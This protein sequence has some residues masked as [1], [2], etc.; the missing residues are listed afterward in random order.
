VSERCR[1]T[2]ISWASSCSRS[3]SIAQRLGGRSY[4][5]YSPVWG[6]RYATII[7]KYTFQALKTLW[8]LFRTRPEVVLVMAPPVV[9]CTPVWIY[10]K[11]AGGSYA[12]DAHTAAFLDPRWRPVMFLQKFFSRRA[13]TTIVTN[14]HLADIVRSWGAHATIV[15]DVPICFP[16]PKRIRIKGEC[17]MV[18]VSS[19]TRDEPLET[20]IEA[21]RRAPEIQFYVTGDYRDADPKLLADKPGN[22]EFTGYLPGSEYV[23]LVMC[24]SAVICLTTSDHTMQRGAYEAIFLGK[25]VITSN[26][27]L[28]REVFHRGVV[29]VD[30]T[31]E[32]IVRGIRQ[33]RQNLDKYTLEASELKQERLK[34]WAGVS[35][36][37]QQLLFSR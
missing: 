14:Q 22:L 6:S 4:M 37:L 20:F 17:A 30:I 24:S 3:D 11:I 36:Q 13:A 31:V 29:H 23:G 12:I 18:F 5:V 32:D 2:A 8:I 34:E 35:R 9:A 15:T 27:K 33:M 16:E 7:F 1:L 21:V 26:F 10:Q 19:F 25:P 28:L